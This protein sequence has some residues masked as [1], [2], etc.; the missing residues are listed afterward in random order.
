MSH[1][2]FCGRFVVAP[3]PAAAF[4]ARDK[5]DCP[6]CHVFLG[7]R[8]NGDSPLCH[9]MCHASFFFTLRTTSGTTVIPRRKTR[10]D[11]PEISSP[12]RSMGV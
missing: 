3:A 9:A 12:V 8:D 11:A 2:D 4:A 7:K 5:G 10:M 6:A 1:A